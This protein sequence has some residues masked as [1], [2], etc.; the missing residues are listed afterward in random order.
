MDDNKKEQE[1]RELI[2]KGDLG[3]L[4]FH[5]GLGRR[6][7]RALQEAKCKAGVDVLSVTDI[8]LIEAKG[9]S[10]TTIGRIHLLKRYLS[11]EYGLADIDLIYEEYDKGGLER[12]NG[13]YGLGG[14][15]MD[16]LRRNGCETGIDILKIDTNHAWTEEK[17]E[18]KSKRFI[19]LLHRYLRAA[20]IKTDP[21]DGK[22]P[23]GNAAANTEGIT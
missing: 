12:L 16:I 11:V 2:D 10:E 21:S 4:V 17:S 20:Y 5:Y 13:A 3:E 23:Q 8:F 9:C 7:L 18:R 19:I 15:V 14:P 6:V 1:F 22:E